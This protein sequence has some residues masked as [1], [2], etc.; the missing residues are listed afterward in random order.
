MN[1]DSVEI[2][3]S[4]KYHLLIIGYRMQKQGKLELRLED[5][6]KISCQLIGIK[7]FINQV[8]GFYLAIRLEL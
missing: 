7:K 4:K 8:F 6:G 1:G 5:T 2:I 3:R